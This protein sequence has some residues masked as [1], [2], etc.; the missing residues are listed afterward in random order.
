[1]ASA[2][3]PTPTPTPYTVKVPDEA[4][5]ELRTRL[6]FTKYPD[7]LEDLDLWQFGVPVSELK[8]LTTYWKDKFDW[9]KAEADM[10]EL[11]NFSTKIEV[12]GFGEL[13]IHCGSF[14]LT[15]SKTRS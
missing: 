12:G 6:S 8:R 9:R 10:N 14:F 2:T 1:M 15:M 4:I 13:D 5:E 11:P 7:Q 3:A